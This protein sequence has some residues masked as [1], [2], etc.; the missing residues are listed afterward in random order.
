LPDSCPNVAV[1]LASNASS[2]DRPPRSRPVA[3]ARRLLDLEHA[4]PGQAGD[5][6]RRD[7]G[8]DALADERVTE[9][10][11]GPVVE[12]CLLKGGLPFVRGAS[13]GG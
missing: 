9:R 2:A 1:A 5:L 8:G 13:C 12:P 6:E 3:D 11:R 7:P 10:A 4:R